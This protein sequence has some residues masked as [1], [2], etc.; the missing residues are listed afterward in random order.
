VAT[1]E[2]LELRSRLSRVGDEV[3]A[4]ARQPMSAADARIVARVAQ[5]LMEHGWRAS[6]GN[7]RLLEMFATKLD[8]SERELLVRLALAQADSH[9]SIARLEVLLATSSNA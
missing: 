5:S 6:C 3:V 9:D 8:T 1:P 7:D 2:M 4:R